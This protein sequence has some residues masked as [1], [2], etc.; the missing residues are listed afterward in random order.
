MNIKLN[1][2]ITVATLGSSIHAKTIR[3]PLHQARA[4]EKTKTNQSQIL[5]QK[6]TKFE[7]LDLII[8]CIDANA[9]NSYFDITEEEVANNCFNKM[10][11]SVTKP[12]ITLTKEEKKEWEKALEEIRQECFR[13]S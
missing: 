10:V 11:L 5:E 4:I 9:N 1:L 12:V 8:K 3:A 6:T 2:L 7:F 13:R